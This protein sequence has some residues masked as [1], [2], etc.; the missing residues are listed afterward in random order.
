MDYKELLNKKLQEKEL[1]DKKNAEI[2]SINSQKQQEHKKKTDNEFKERFDVFYNS[3]NS[4]KNNNYELKGVLS[5]FL[6]KYKD[7][8]ILND[9]EYVRTSFCGINISALPTGIEIIESLTAH[10]KIYIGINLIPKKTIFAEV[11]WTIGDKEL[12]NF[13]SDFIEKDET[14]QIP[15]SIYFGLKSSNKIPIKKKIHEHIIEKYYYAIE[16]EFDP[17]GHKNE[18]IFRSLNDR[19]IKSRQSSIYFANMSC[20]QYMNEN[21]LNIK[22]KKDEF[23]ENKDVI[24]KDL[25]RILIGEIEENELL[26]FVTKRKGEFILRP[27]DI[28]NRHWDKPHSTF[29]GLI[30]NN[31]PRYIASELQKNANIKTFNKQ[32]IKYIL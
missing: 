17:I 31:Y 13:M 28:K 15:H 23:K 11:T 14:F 22:I 3:I 9:N 6:N 20:L 24:I 30:I 1:E 27:F 5:L 32:N 4:I 29:Y 26:K 16:I 21:E 2:E 8:T 12:C 19:I 25:L 7:I 18:Y 10:N